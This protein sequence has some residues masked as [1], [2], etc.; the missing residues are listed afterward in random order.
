MN[1]FQI[2]VMCGFA[3][4]LLVMW[5]AISLWEI[6]KECKK[7]FMSRPMSRPNTY[8]RNRR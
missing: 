3:I 1:T 4:G 5:F 7:D 2:G 6:W 8:P